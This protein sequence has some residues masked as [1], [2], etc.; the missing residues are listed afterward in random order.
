VRIVKVIR[1]NERLRSQAERPRPGHL[2]DGANLGDRTTL[3]RHHE[4]FP[5]QD[6]M[7]QSIQIALHL[8]DANVHSAESGDGSPRGEVGGA[9]RISV[10]VAKPFGDGRADAEVPHI[11]PAQ[12]A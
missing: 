11:E 8:L 9:G 6:A 12:E 5:I 4:R 2:L 7:K 10:D 1:H 3:T